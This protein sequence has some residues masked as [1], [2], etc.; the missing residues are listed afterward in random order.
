MVNW[1][2]DRQTDSLTH[3]LIN[4]L[5]WAE[6]FL[7]SYQVF[8][9]SRN[10]LHFMESEGSLLHS[11]KLATCQYPVADQA[12]PCPTTHFLKTYFKIILPSTCRFSKSPPSV[13]LPHQNPVC[14]TPFPH[15]CYLPQSSHS[16]SFDHQKNIWWKVHIIKLVA[17]F[18]VNIYHNSETF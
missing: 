13:K 8:S 17:I 14:T 4:Y 3:W 12:N 18:M 7:R 15:P 11:Q 16:S 6:C 5:H 9:W 1:L 2:S 10:S